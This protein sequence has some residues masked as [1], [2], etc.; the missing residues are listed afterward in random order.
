MTQPL[1]DIPLV[2]N[3]GNPTSLGDHAG[4]VVLIV[5]VAS[6]CGLTPQYEALER[7]YRERR[8]DGLVVL[9]CPA[10]DFGGQEPGT[11]AEIAS[12]CATSYDVSF[13][14]LAKGPVTG[15]D[16]QPL[17][18]A[19]ITAQPARDGDGGAAMRA[20]LEGYGITVGEG[21]ELIWNF[22]KFVVGR[23]GQVVARFAPDVAPDDPALVSALDAALAE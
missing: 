16:K 9:G 2:D 12:F 15:P 1:A 11:D 8:A 10:N 23:D 5:N 14:M 20:R 21:A 4:H 7:L 6:K 19:L 17:F 13:P 18:A 22:E 3:T